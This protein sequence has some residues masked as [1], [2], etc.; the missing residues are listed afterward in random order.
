[1]TSETIQLGAVTLIGEHSKT[2]VRVTLDNDFGS[3]AIYLTHTEWQSLLAIADT[4]RA[5]DKEIERLKAQIAEAKQASTALHD[6]VMEMAH[7]PQSASRA[8][9]VG[10]AI[11]KLDDALADTLRGLVAVVDAAKALC[12][13]PDVASG[14]N[15]TWGEVAASY[16]TGPRLLA[17]LKSAVD[18]LATATGKG[19]GN[20]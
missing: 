17:K 7:D 6:R 11:R 20:G 5:A 2:A 3:N 18:A 16:Q 1:M 15:A 10:V 12:A 4:K 8:F 14:E 19:P 9:A 13:Q